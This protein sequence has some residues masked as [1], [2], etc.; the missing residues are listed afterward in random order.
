MAIELI[1]RNYQIEFP[2]PPFFSRELSVLTLLATNIQIFKY[3]ANIY[4]L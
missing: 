4:N 1:V 2:P 3:K